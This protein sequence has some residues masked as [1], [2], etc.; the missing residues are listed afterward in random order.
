MIA[1]ALYLWKKLNAF[2]LFSRRWWLLQQSWSGIAGEMVPGKYLA[3]RSFQI[4]KKLF[5]SF[6]ETRYKIKEMQNLPKFPSLVQVAYCDSTWNI[7]LACQVQ[8]DECG[9]KRNSNGRARLREISARQE[10]G[11]FAPIGSLSQDAVVD[12]EN[13]IWKYDF[14]S[15]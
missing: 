4:K 7:C 8:C 13:V 3:W 15:L 11:F 6:V 10:K 2:S 5:L 1:C 9:A 12:N 14:A